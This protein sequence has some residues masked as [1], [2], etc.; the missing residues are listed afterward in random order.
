[1]PSSTNTTN[2][3]KDVSQKSSATQEPSSPGMIAA[4]TD[5]RARVKGYADTNTSKACFYNAR[6][7]DSDNDVP[8][9]GDRSSEFEEELEHI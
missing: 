3:R 6:V 7:T 5:G 4:R 9:T 1:M 2:T 8:H